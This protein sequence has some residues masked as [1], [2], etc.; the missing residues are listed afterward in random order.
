MA[1]HGL[2]ALGLPP[3]TGSAAAVLA[4]RQHAL[5]RL[6]PLATRQ[7][8][9]RR[10]RLPQLITLA[11]LIRQILLLDPSAVKLRHA[12]RRM[13]D[14]DWMRQVDRGGDFGRLPNGTSTRI[15][16][17][18]HGEVPETSA[19]PSLRLATRPNAAFLLVVGG[20]HA[21]QLLGWP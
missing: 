16:K 9:L 17:Q 4:E 1:D 3:S 10:L 20:G 19:P 6:R 12:V 7:L 15:A 8:L 21:K 18:V 5:A 13:F 14:H 11:H 2:I